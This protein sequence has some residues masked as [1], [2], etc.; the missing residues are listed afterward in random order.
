MAELIY[1]SNWATTNI[2][3][4]QVPDAPTNFMARLVQ[5][6]DGFGAELVW[7][8]DP[9]ATRYELEMADSAEFNDA[10]QIYS[11]DTPAFTQPIEKD[12]WFR[13]CSVKVIPE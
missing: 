12:S 8:D 6:E 10:V 11:G 1:K 4:P 5:L 13:V 3:L 7:D 2:A 9:N